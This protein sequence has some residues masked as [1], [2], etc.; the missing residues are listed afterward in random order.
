MSKPDDYSEQKIASIEKNANDTKKET[1]VTKK[2]A[3]NIICIL[4]ESFCD[5]DEIKFLN[6]N[7]DPIPTFH[8]LEKNYTSGY[9][10]VP[11]VGAGTANT[12]FEVLLSLIHI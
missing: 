11:V 4:L 10:T 12:E 2:N 3:P 8:N 7:Q 6:Y 5:P 1:T 9:L